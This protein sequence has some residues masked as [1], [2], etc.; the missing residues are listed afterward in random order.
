MR[1]R[2]FRWRAM[3]DFRDAK[4]ATADGTRQP[5]STLAAKELNLNKPGSNPH[6]RRSAPFALVALLVALAIPAAAPAQDPSVDQYAPGTPDAGGPTAPDP[7]PNAGDDSDF[8]AASG[9]R[10][11]AAGSSG[12]GGSGGSGGGGSGGSGGSGADPAATAATDASTVPD[13][14]V[15]TAGDEPQ[16]KAQ[17][18]LARIADGAEQQR[19]AAADKGVDTNAATELLRSDSGGG[20]GMG[21]FLWV[22]LGATLAWAVCSGLIRHRRGSQP[23]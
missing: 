10:T 2:N 7:V 1:G 14:V 22:F 18:D 23:A 9:N 20:S 13:E 12:G 15:T 3:L 5:L 16:N 17:R 21:I 19:A 8:G 11:P 4:S 6:F